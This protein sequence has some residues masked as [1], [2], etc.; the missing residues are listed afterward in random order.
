LAQTKTLTDQVG[1]SPALFQPTEQAQL[2]PATFP[3]KL[4]SISAKQGF[5]VE[6][7]LQLIIIVGCSKDLRL[8]SSKT[9]IP[10]TGAALGPHAKLLLTKNSS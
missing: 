5:E 2:I 10:I 6:P 1:L 7:Y 8:V 9:L 4:S 3:D